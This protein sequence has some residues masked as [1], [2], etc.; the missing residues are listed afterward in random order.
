MTAPGSGE[1][2]AR[3]PLDG[4]D[5]DEAGD[6]SLGE[7]LREA[8]RQRAITLADVERDTRISAAYIEALEAERFD[9]LPAPVYARGFLRS[10]ARYL[11]LD[12]D[13]TLALMPGD[14]PR[15]PDLEPSAGLMRGPSS[16]L[17]A[18]P[19]LNSPAF[20][21]VL[22]I[23]LLVALAFF[24]LPRLRDGDD[25]PATPSPAAE[26]A[27]T[28]TA[29]APAPAA[30]V[31]PFEVGETPNFI[32]VD[33]DEATE[34]LTQLRL[35]FVVIEVPTNEAPAGRVFGQSP[36]PGATIEAGDDVTLIV[37]GGPP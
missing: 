7:L 1:E 2:G 36:Q 5:L 25:A 4:D 32:G 22:A 33:R 35:S 30:T 10:Y 8:R 9:V 20:V 3:P 11:G 23:A 16:S 26:T 14:L 24:A 21:A 6:V 37:S 13:A 15:P 31:P 28:A 27:A 17:P 18:L 34:L 19:S 12:V 29:T